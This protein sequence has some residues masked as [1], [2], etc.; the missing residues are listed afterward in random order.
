MSTSVKENT[1]KKSWVEKTP[2]TYVLLFLIIVIAGLL[3]YVIPAGEYERVL[4]A[5]RQMVVPDSFHYVDVSP[6]GFFDFFNAVVQGMIS[7]ASIVFLCFFL[8]GSIQIFHETNAINIGIS[9]AI[10]K[11]GQKGGTAL[12][13]SAM[14][15]FSI[16]GAFLGWVEGA[17]PFAP[18]AVA[19]AV[20]LGYDSLVGVS[21][22]ILS[23]F[24]SF[25]VG[26]TNPFTVGISHSLAELP[27]YSGMSLRL[28]VYIIVLFI[29][30]HHVLRYANKTKKDPSQSLMQGIDIGSLKYEVNDFKDI[31]FT[32]RHKAVLLTLLGTVLLSLYGIFSFGWYINEMG[33][34]FILGAMVA[35]LIAKFTPGKI[36]D[37]FILGA[38]NITFGALVI[39]LARGIQWILEKGGISDTIINM[40]AS[41]L[42]HLPTS[43][44]AVGMFIAHAVINF[45]IPSGS[46]QAMAT[47]P[48]M[49]P[50]SDVLGITRQT[51][52]LA[53]QFG[54]G[55][56]N[57]MF[58]TVGALLVYLAFGKVPFDRWIKFIL[59]LL[60]KI[61]IVAVVTLV[62]AVLIGYGPF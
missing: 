40:M 48:I 17:I 45:F 56:A 29:S 20:G 11:F 1:K 54:D 25:A 44:A 8:G 6:V 32:M 58:P 62:A 49:I 60:L 13:I 12:I 35:G 5:G 34:V 14:I 31:P 4:Q 52:V 28:V 42:N 61:F 59:P 51:A 57:I 9:K 53:F 16:L 24:L 38:K 41:L 19:L 10:L 47:M 21:I 27:L 33:A 26:P 23:T 50:L 2:H 30:I 7:S 15:F 37:S 3:S 39:G 55:F 22:A 46:G 43:I 36:A 18:L